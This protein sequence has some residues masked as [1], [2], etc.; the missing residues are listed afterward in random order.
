MIST[1]HGRAKEA[2]RRVKKNREQRRPDDNGITRMTAAVRRTGHHGTSAV[3][4]DQSALMPTDLITLCP[5][6][7]FLGDELA[8]VCGRDD[9]RRAPKVGK[10]CL[11]LGIGEARV[12]LLVELVDDVRRRVLGYADAIP[13]ARLVARHE[14]THGRDVRQRVRAGRGETPS[15]PVPTDLRAFPQPP[16][17]AGGKNP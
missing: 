5:L 3:T 2:W 7:G 15:R 6:L 4:A 10:P 14:L 12:D 13:V 11:H 1:I 9:K 17:E 16:G 8:K